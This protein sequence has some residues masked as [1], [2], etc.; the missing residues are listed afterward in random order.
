MRIGRFMQDGRAMDGVVEGDVVHR[1]GPW[2]DAADPWQPFRLPAM[3]PAALAEL[4]VLQT[5]PLAALA[6]LPPID[7]A[8]RI[9]C[10]GLNYRAHADEVG[11]EQ[12]GHPGL[13]LRAFDTL[14]GHGAA[15]L[16]PRASAQ[17]DFEGEIAVV[18]GRPG[19]HI[20]R[21]D[22]LAHVCGY[23][24]LMDG[25]LRDFQ[26]HSVTAGKNFWRSGAIG[27]WVLTA[28]A[29]PDPGSLQL[30]TRLNGQV[31]Q[32]AGADSM[33]HDIPALI[34][35]VSQWL[36]LRAGDVIATGTPAGVGLSRTPPLWLVPGD[37]L[38][39]QV[40]P[41]GCLRNPIAQEV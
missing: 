4:P 6:C 35:Y 8:S 29:V 22:A 9:V 14:Q 13:F 40:D 5:L 19:R 41:V 11:R 2:H 26:K 30:T 23:T 36:P 37:V 32:Q 17:Y 27:P 7:L 18:I 20:A 34:A 28:D 38:E 1:V 16:R 31:V 21:A 15:L 12:A 24:C 3:A 39:V 25:S 33:V 10:V